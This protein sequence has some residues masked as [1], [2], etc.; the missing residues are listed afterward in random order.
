[1]SSRNTYLPVVCVK[2]IIEKVGEPSE[3]VHAV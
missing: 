3:E 2:T 1:M